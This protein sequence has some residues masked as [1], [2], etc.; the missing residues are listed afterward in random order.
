VPKPEK[1]RA[2]RARAGA[3]RYPDRVPVAACFGGGGSFGIAFNLGVAVGLR[4]AGID[5][6]RGPMLGTSAGAYTAAALRSDVSFA[7]VIEAWPEEFSWRV[8]RAVD[9]TRPV[10]GDR[11]DP[12]VAA[13]AVRLSRWRR[14]VLWSG[15]DTLADIV[16]ASSSPP[17][18]AWPHKVARRRYVDGGYASLASADLA[19][20]AE[21]LVLVTPIWRD[22]GR[23]GRRAARRLDR[24]TQ[25]YTSLG[26]GRVLHV[27]PDAPILE[28]NGHQLRNM[29]D[30]ELARR[31]FPL[32]C[33]LG[34]RV[35]REFSDVA[36]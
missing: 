10:F 32:A 7:T 14:T 27:A 18:F 25:A 31:V 8:A 6:T 3:E 23:V 36:P 19:P 13:V 30:P 16:A 26:A 5:V 35:G 4:A 17:P 15:A 20:L 11:R 28:L 33:D 21:L 22:A 9:V 24:E 12:D 34:L 1:I 2:R 29:F